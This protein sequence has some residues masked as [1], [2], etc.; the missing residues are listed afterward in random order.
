MRLNDL[1]RQS[2]KRRYIV[3]RDGSFD[4]GKERQHDD[5]TAFDLI[6]SGEKQ[7][8]IYASNK[9]EKK[10]CLPYLCVAAVIESGL[11]VPDVYK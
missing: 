2:Y 8:V 5:L 1:R 9:L 10:N 4:V 11:F 7:V 3:K 6:T